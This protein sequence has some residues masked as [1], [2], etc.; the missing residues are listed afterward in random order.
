MTQ[1]NAAVTETETALAVLRSMVGIAD[2]TVER[3]TAGLTLT[4][5]RALRVIAERTPVTMGRVAAELGMNPS[6][7]TRA[8]DRLEASKLLHRA[9][10]PLNKRETL[11]APTARGRRLVDRVDHDRRSVLSE[12]LDRMEPR[13]R[14]RLAL[15]FGA[16][17]DAAEAVLHSGDNADRG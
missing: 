3:G 11:L 6:S 5:F 12:V 13:A 10:N 9:P 1:T 14:E 17:A 16:F 7:V 2:T 8:C 15:V 4:Q